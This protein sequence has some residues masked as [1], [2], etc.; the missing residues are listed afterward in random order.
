VG[1]EAASQITKNCHYIS[2]FLTKPWEF[3]DRRLWYYDFDNDTFGRAP[4]KY[5]YAEDEINSSE[6]ETWLKQTLEDPVALVRPRLMKA[7]PRAL[8][9]WRFFRAAVLMLW[10]QGFRA[11]S[12]EGMEDRR[13][14]DEIARM[15]IEH[16]DA[17][18][19]MIGR[20]FSLRLAFTIWTDDKFYPLSVPS[21]GTFV[22]QVA[23]SG[24]A[25]GFS[26]GVGLPLDPRCALVAL[27][28]ENRGKLDLS[29][30]RQS[31]ANYSVGL[32]HSRRVVL[33]P[34][35]R[36]LP[37]EHLRRDLHE[38]REINDS[39]PTNLH[40]LRPLIERAFAIGG[41]VVAR[42]DVGRIIPPKP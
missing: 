19:Q 7:D 12:V 28:V 16:L 2:R 3:E 23:D 4:S 9:D 13:H 39:L 5:L 17:M 1:D 27:P 20:D 40:K 35:V 32:S 11:S 8:D 18:V 34:D 36:S 31:L 21:Q 26:L 30:L 6:V 33:H 14:L 25:S 41:I 15:P 22:V 37:E 42:D 29:G 38:L 10:L 24:C